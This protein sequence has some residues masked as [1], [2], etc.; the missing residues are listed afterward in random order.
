MKTPTRKQAP[1]VK[2]AGNQPEPKVRS[3]WWEL[4]LVPA[5]LGSLLL[6]ASFPPLNL[7]PLAWLAPLPWLWLIRQSSLGGWKPYLQIWFAGSV[8]WLLML[9][10]I[11]LAHPALYGGWLAL[12]AYLAVY[13]VLFISIARVAVHQLR[14][15]LF[16]TAP[17]VFVGLELLRGQ[18]I[19][20]FASGN[21]AHTQIALPVVLQIADL[22]GAYMLSFVMMLVAATI[23]Q[24]FPAKWFG[25][26]EPVRVSRVLPIAVTSCA[27]IATI[28]YGAYRQQER[29]PPSNRP[30]LKVALIQGSLDTRFD[31]DFNERVN[32]N[33]SHY[34][35]LTS[36]AVAA[37][38]GLDLIVWP[39]SSFAIPEITAAE[40]PL[41]ANPHDKQIASRREMV[42]ESG[43]P[44]HNM[45]AEGIQAINK[46]A[47]PRTPGE[48]AVLPAT[49]TSFLFGTSTYVYDLTKDQGFPDRNFNTA[50]LVG[51]AGQIIGRYYK[52]HAVM[53]G[54]YVPVADLLPWLS[55]LT[56]LGSG[57]SVGEAPTTLSVK[58]YSLS[59]NICFEST[60]PHLIRK[61]IIESERTSKRPIDAIVNVTNDGWFWGSSILDLHFRCS[62]FRAI[63]NRKP[64]VIAA[65][66]GISAHIDG[67]GRVLQH[68]LKRQP[69]V[70]VAD[71]VADGRA[72]PYHLWGDAPAWL[73][74]WITWAL[75][76]YGV[77][78]RRVTT[79][80]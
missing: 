11:R 49:G 13:L 33:F 78:T 52:M 10:G 65:N 57:M 6:W 51:P 62:V 12:S 9:Q 27:L 53:F 8:H 28:A 70:L 29:P 19:S 64:V 63:E 76:L 41:L 61:Q 3:A 34:G 1:A 5:L 55:S 54:E 69:E 32:E 43:K 40:L 72:S 26:A 74:A 31:Q 71:V 75:A 66:T 36:D 37:H 16:I 24:L 4:P 73:C 56:P 59:P 79:A 35:K 21:L 60:V 22:G 77:W 48:T 14:W 58:G 18:L 67:N 44:F 68:G 38:R 2:I 30:P 39:E 17:I 80:R 23:A 45:L 20:G 47:Q 50:L 15:P 7:W 46:P 25:V 42:T